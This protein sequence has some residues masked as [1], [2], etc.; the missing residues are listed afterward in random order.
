MG[1]IF[2]LL[3][4]PSNFLLEGWHC[5]FYLVG[6]WSFLYSFKC[7]WALF[8]DADD[9]LE[10]DFILSRFAFQ[11]WLGLFRAV[12][13]LWGSFY[14]TVEAIAFLCTLPNATCILKVL[15]LLLFFTLTGGRTKYFGA[16]VNS[17]DCSNCSFQVALS[18]ASGNFLPC[19]HWSV[20]RRR[21]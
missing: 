2:L 16:Y 11:L 21:L 5:K 8:W 20:L 13:R 19:V 4:M 18:L 10:N 17:R 3:C 1:G 12:F 15:L 7:I 14:S 9:L 6:Y